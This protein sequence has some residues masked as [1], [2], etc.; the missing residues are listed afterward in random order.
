MG[1]SNDLYGD[2]DVERLRVGVVGC[3]YWG[4]KHLR[5]L[6][7]LPGIEVVAIDSNRH[8]LAAAR[9]SAGVTTHTSLQDALDDVD[10][11]VVATSPS[12]HAE[13]ALAAL[14]AGKHVL[15]EKPLATTT[16]DAYEM[17][18][19]ANEAGRVLMVG[20]TFEYNS[21]VR[22]LRD[23]IVDDR[24]GEIYYIDSARLNLGLY[25][26][27]VNVVWDL[28]VHDISIANYLLGRSPVAVSAWGLRHAHRDFE[29]VAYLR[30]HYE[31]PGVDVHV[32]VSWL[33]PA[34]VRRVTVVGSSTMAVYNDLSTD[35]RVRLYDKGIDVRT[36]LE[37]AGHPPLTYRYG[38]IVSPY[39]EFKEP[40]LVED[41]HFI[42]C[43]REGKQ[44]LTDG[45]NGTA[46]VAVLEA[47]Q[48]AMVS[49]HL[50]GVEIPQQNYTLV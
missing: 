40:L 22:Y 46:V 35:E 4:S 42:S 30:L 39:I 38:D 14:T 11:V 7:A 24:L 16:S 48:R 34:K 29:D 1:I 36:P 27:D 15:V 9:E 6:R 45:A 26:P 5:V 13:L 49:G 17:T 41:A 18:R 28:A 37:P 25:Q 3:G 43:V 23:A 2:G 21:A 33:D 31:D 32:H 12:S 8:V 10:A 20:H 44:P 19:V 47:A 50:A